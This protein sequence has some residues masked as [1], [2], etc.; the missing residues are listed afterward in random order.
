M[1]PGFVSRLMEELN[2][3]VELPEFSK[4]QALKGS[5]KF[6]NPPGEANYI[7]WLGGRF[8]N[9]VANQPSYYIICRNFDFFIFQSIQLVNYCSAVSHNQ[10]ICQT[11]IF[12]SMDVI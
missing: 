10:L 9:F 2:S 12:H 6:H 8:L 3:L 5:F 7:G 4:L 11:I 1:L